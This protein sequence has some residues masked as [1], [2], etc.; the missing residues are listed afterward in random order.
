MSKSTKWALPLFL[1]FLFFSTVFPIK[2][3]VT[4]RLLFAP[5]GEPQILKVEFSTL[6][7]FH[8]LFLGTKVINE[9]PELVEVKRLGKTELQVS[10]HRLEGKGSIWIGQFPFWR[11]TEV[12]VLPSARD[13]DRDGFPDVAELQSENDRNLFRELVVDLAR[14]QI[15]YPSPLWQ[16]KDCGGLVRF[17]YR[18]AL[19]Q[20]DEAWFETLGGTWI[21][22][23]DISAYHYPQ[24]PMI[25]VNLFRTKPGEF[26]P[27]TVAEDFSVFASVYH[28][29]AFNVVPLGKR[30][31]LAKKG[32]LLFFFQPDYFEM[33]YHVM[34]Y[35][36]EGKVIYHTGPLA[37]S[38]GE[39]REISLDSLAQHPDSRWHPTLANPAFLGF[40]R[41]KILD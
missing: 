26:D 38:E 7:G 32:D 36:G 10:P 14:S 11:K 5:Q 2:G 23:Q 1:V 37:E 3:E 24:I 39:V 18:E 4:D 27:T 9:T 29:L 20:H 34:L 12:V 35:Q 30:R 33:P 21:K 28:L 17:A 13:D 25:G 19:K 40:F 22:G 41:W 31:E 8:P 15:A 16:E 6:W